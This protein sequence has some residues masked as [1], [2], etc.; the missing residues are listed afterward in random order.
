MARLSIIEGS[1]GENL[2]QFSA[3]PSALGYLY[4]F[5]TALLEYLRRDDPAIDLSIEVLDD[6]AL[7]GAQT[8][9]L[10]TKL[11]IEPGSLTDGSAGLWKTLR[12]WSESVDVTP[13]ALLVLITTASAPDNSIAALLRADDRDEE[14]AHDRLVAYARAATGKTLA[15][16]RNAFLSLAEDKRRAMV[17]R[18]VIADAAPVIDNLDEEFE[19]SLRHA[20][21]L[22]TR[23]HL[24][25]RLREWWLLRAERHLIDVAAGLSPEISS[26]EIEDRIASLRD[27]LTAD[28]LPNDFEEL[29][30]P[31]DEEV[32]AD[33]RAFVMQLRLIALGN[34]RIRLAVHDHNRAFTQ[35]SRWL[36]EELLMG[37]ELEAYERR[38]KDEWRRIWLPETDNELDGITDDNALR[39]G[40]EVFKGCNDGVVEPI[41][42][43]VSA[44]HI[45]RGSFHMLADELE[46]GWH[47]E[48]LER[49]E[50]MLEEARQ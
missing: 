14:G 32:A 37:D 48:W 47:H 29:T 35:R 38:L 7:E 25:T 43:K 40:R 18:I 17:G 24:V 41:R 46:I 5:E 10:Q 13:D 33:K 27:Q 39:R 31:S 16:A 11:E 36:R 28:N 30:A 8:E 2:T 23:P 45:T 44:P 3:A 12:V 34:E 6:I 26:A 20:A 21:P 9:L 15:P 42:P 4:Q 49:V 1:G 19:R 50:V 22:A